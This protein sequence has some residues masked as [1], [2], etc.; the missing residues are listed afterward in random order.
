M[1]NMID[2]PVKRKIVRY[3]PNIQNIGIAI[4][5]DIPAGYKN[6]LNKIN[7]S[8]LKTKASHVHKIHKHES[9]IIAIALFEYLWSESKFF[10]KSPITMFI[11]MELLNIF[12]YVNVQ[13]YY[14]KLLK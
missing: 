13:I 3:N 9:V 6:S 5:I 10:K 14:N 7:F 1:V 12:L 11:I 8:N 4:I 2:N